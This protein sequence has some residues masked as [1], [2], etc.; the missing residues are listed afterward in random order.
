MACKNCKGK[1]LVDD[2]SKLQKNIM[3]QSNS[4]NKQVYDKTL[5]RITT[6]EQIMVILFGFLPMFV[7]YIVIIKFII[8]LL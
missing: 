8:S 5:G 4:L 1:K 2:V 3:S 7:G 6:G